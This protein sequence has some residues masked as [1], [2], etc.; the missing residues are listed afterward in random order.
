MKSMVFD[1]RC[2]SNPIGTWFESFEKNLNRWIFT[3]TK[4]VINFHM[5]MLT[6][7]ASDFCSPRFSR[8]IKRKRLY[9]GILFKHILLNCCC[10]FPILGVQLFQLSIHFGN[11]NNSVKASVIG[12]FF[13]IITT[14]LWSKKLKTRGLIF[15][16]LHLVLQRQLLHHLFLLELQ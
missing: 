2:G 14:G 5:F 8:N 16:R 4:F 11:W 13:K 6:A 15:F 1:F 10:L 3:F 9:I 12:T 7:I